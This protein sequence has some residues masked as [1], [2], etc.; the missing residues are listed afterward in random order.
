MEGTCERCIREGDYNS[1]KD[2]R[3]GFIVGG[4]EGFQ[5]KVEREEGLLERVS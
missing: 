2:N 4:E 5:D 3:I 1:E